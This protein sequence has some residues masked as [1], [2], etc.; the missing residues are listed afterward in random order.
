MRAPAPRRDD[1]RPGDAGQGRHRRAARAARRPRR[2]MPVVVV[3]A[4]SP[5]H[6]ARAVDAL[7]EGAFELVSKPAAGEPFETFV[8]E[9]DEKVR[10]PPQPRP[11]MPPSG[12]AAPRR[13]RP[14]RARAA[15]P[16]PPWKRQPRRRTAKARSSSSPARPA[17]R[18]RWPT[19]C[20]SCPPRSAPGTLIVQHMP[21]GFTGSLATRL[22]NASRLKVVEA[23]RR[24]G[25]RAR[26]RAARA[27]RQPPAPE[28][29]PPRPPERRRRHRRPAP[30]RRPDD[31][32]RRRA[33]GRP[34]PAGRADRHGPRRPGGRQARQEV[35][36]P[37]PRRGGV[38]LHR[39][40]HAAGDRRGRPGRPDPRPLRSSARD[41]GRWA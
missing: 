7:A 18:A 27:R 41:Q 26:H 28:R 5:A 38:E 31:Q 13:S 11:G 16:A 39:L 19:S 30:A 25:D 2:P 1:A 14:P 34:P 29:R 22:D 9:L 35:R 23:G 3:S 37:H 24:R 33:L 36:R 17:A 4:F 10:P 40:R 32:G 8:K 15:P 6:G 20:P 21:P 12:A